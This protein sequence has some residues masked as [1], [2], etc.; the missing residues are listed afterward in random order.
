MI[1]NISIIPKSITLKTLL[2]Y[3]KYDGL[4]EISYILDDMTMVSDNQ[5][6]KYNIDEHDQV[7]IFPQYLIKVYNKIIVYLRKNH[8]HTFDDIFLDDEQRI[9]DEVGDSLQINKKLVVRILDDIYMY[10]S[11]L[12]KKRENVDVSSLSI[13]FG[14]IKLFYYQNRCV[15]LIDK[16]SINYNKN[17]LDNEDL[18]LK[19]RDNTN[20]IIIKKPLS[21]YP[22]NHPIMNHR[23]YLSFS[24]LDKEKQLSNL[25]DY[26]MIRELVIEIILGKSSDIIIDIAS[27]SDSSGLSLD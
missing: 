25:G 12:S 4:G 27:D 1:P 21:F 3:V 16:I 13:N 14:D 20:T 7:K 11:Y 6:I 5:L 23:F 8:R 18:K 24:K 15:Y 10:N 17:N 26:L 9:V 22:K 2:G 19:H